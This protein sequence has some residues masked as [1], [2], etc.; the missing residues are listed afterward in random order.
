[1]T[2]ISTHPTS[3]SLGAGR[4]APFKVCYKCNQAAPPGADLQVPA[5][6]G[7]HSME[8]G[9][10]IPLPRS[11]AGRSSKTLRPGGDKT[12]YCERWSDTPCTPGLCEYCRS[13]PQDHVLTAFA[14]RPPSTVIP[15]EST[16]PSTWTKV[17][18]TSA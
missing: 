14:S 8:V 2:S 4:P 7:R 15:I 10:V 5:Q 17:P 11:A 16:G 6:L 18:A 1:M 12:E 13:L 9:L 3:A